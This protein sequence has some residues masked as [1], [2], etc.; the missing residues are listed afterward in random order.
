MDVVERFFFGWFGN[1]MRS[2][3]GMPPL[4]TPISTEQLAPGYQMAPRQIDGVDRY[5]LIDPSGAVAAVASG[6]E[7]S[8]AGDLVPLSIY[9]HVPPIEIMNSFTND[10][11]KPLFSVL[12]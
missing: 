3:R 1:T 12:D 11:G 8:A 10:T 9:L 4:D 6:G 2:N 5:V 7:I